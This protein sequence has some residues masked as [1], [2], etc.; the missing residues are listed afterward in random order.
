MSKIA[1]IMMLLVL[2]ITFAAEQQNALPKTNGEG[3]TLTKSQL[4]HAQLWSLSRDEYKRYLKILNSPRGYFTPNLEKNPLLALALEAETQA[5]R[6]KYADHWVRLQYENN[7]KVISWQLDV[8]EA[9]KRQYPGVPRFTYKKPAL[10]KYSISRL[11]S[12]SSHAGSTIE[13]LLQKQANKPRSQLYIAINQCD[14]CVKAFKQQYSDLKSGKIAG[15]DI[16]FISNPT[17]VQ[18]IEWATDQKLDALEVN[19]QRIVTLNIAEK[20]VKSVPFVEF[21]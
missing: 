6:K 12:A 4:S 17:K 18:I 19:D 8:N 21:K 10:S 14:F 7:V 11:T 20:T 2:P 3:L 13:A 16:H 5:E 9:W 1:L 15:L